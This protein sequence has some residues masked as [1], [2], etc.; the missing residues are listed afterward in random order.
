MDTRK[1]PRLVRN[2]VVLFGGNVVGQLAYF[3][4]LVYVARALGPATFGIWNFAQVFVLYLL[5]VG[6]VGL[7]VTSIRAVA[8]EP[9][10]TRQ[11]LTTVIVIRT[12]LALILFAGTALAGWVGLMPSDVVPL[13]LLFA[14]ILVPTGATLEWVYEAHQ[15]VHWVSLARILKGVL[16]LGLTPVLTTLGPPAMAATISFVVSVTVP[17]LILTP[18]AIRRFGWGSVRVALQRARGLLTLSWPV[19]VVSMLTQY[20]WFLGTMVAGYLCTRDDLGWYTAGHRPIIFVWAYVVVSSHRVLL[21]ALSRLVHASQDE[22]RAFVERVFRIILVAVVP[23][24]FIGYAVAPWMLPFVFGPDYAGSVGVFRVLVFALVIAIVRSIFEVGLLAEDRQM[25][26][27]RGLL[28]LS[29]VYT[30]ATPLAVMAWGIIGAGWAATVAELI[31]LV[32]LLTSGDS[33]R[34]GTMVRQL[35]RITIAI[36]PG[37]TMPM[38][39]PSFGIVETLIVGILAYC[40]VAFGLRAIRQDDITLLRRITRR[41]SLE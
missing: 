39:L 40:G 1:G 36:L 34:A 4:G 20:C 7:E 6:D 3:G 15:E 41:H 17:V 31:F 2:F 27:L 35:I 5:R 33:D 29:V 25:K 9:E 24:G 22:Y 30:V 13:T 12:V 16:F 19:G 8:R 32:F 18:I 37:V 26:Y 21:P 23:L 38:V 14:I 10:T 11:Q 28:L